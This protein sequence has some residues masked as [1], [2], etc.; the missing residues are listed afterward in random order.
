MLNMDSLSLSLSLHCILFV[1]LDCCK[2][3]HCSW[4][5][6]KIIVHFL[7][8][9][10]QDKT[11]G[12][13]SQRIASQ[14]HS[15]QGLQ[16]HLEGIRDYLEK[17]A[18][19]KLPINHQILYQLQDIFNLLPNL[20]LEE[21]T[22]SFA[23]KTNDQLLVVYVASLI[24]SV[25]ALHNLIGNKVANRE[26]ERQEKEGEKKKEELKAK[27]EKEK[28]KEKEVAASKGEGESKDSKE[29]K[30]SED[31]TNKKKWHDFNY[32]APSNYGSRIYIL[33]FTF[34]LG[35]IYLLSMKSCHWL[36]T[37]IMQK[38]L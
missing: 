5:S 35:D 13:L 19:K 21:F 25:I 37:K 7:P 26:A 20:N 27:K 31:K 18:M 30:K 1:Y 24:R 34:I 6:V 15:L 22:R 28:E 9:D 36:F 38:Y 4:E 29:E 16:T 11:V 17:V 32:Q 10:I 8:R 14:I 3:S 23:V 2:S 33:L 12:T